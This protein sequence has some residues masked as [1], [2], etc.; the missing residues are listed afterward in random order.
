MKKTSMVL[1][2]VAAISVCMAFATDSRAKRSRESV[3]DF[4]GKRVAIIG[5]SYS[6][7]RGCIAGYSPYYPQ[8]DVTSVGQT[9][10]SLLCER[11]GALLHF[12]CSYSGSTVSS[13][14]YDGKDFTAIS[15][16]TRADKC[17]GKTLHPDMDNIRPDVFVICGGT[18]DSWAG[19]PV[20]R[21]KYS[22]WTAEDLKA[23]APSL[24][25]LIDNLL[26]YNPGAKIINTVNLVNPDA[27]WDGN[28]LSEAVIDAMDEVCR[29][30]GIDNIYL[31]NIDK[32][33]S[34]P[35]ARGMSQIAD[36]IIDFYK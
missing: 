31:R 23:F 13:T 28:G 34:H 19:S 20:G 25:C 8:L 17:F 16:V 21:P 32:K 7:F 9:W 15:F 4:K 1:A 22:D 5:D 27:S 36:Q 30:Y 3:F 35:T 10:W 24:C 6:T 12:N 26:K 14:G 11:T 2:F 33:E 18:N 29:H